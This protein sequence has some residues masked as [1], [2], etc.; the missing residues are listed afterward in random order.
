MLELGLTEDE[1]PALSG[2]TGQVIGYKNG[3]E[4][5]YNILIIYSKAAWLCC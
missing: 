5:L 4:Q 1:V 2:G 3:V